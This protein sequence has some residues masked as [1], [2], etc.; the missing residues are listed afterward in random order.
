[1]RM[2]QANL[3]REERPAYLQH[4]TRD[5]L[6]WKEVVIPSPTSCPGY[7]GLQA[8]NKAEGEPRSN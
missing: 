1:M 8:S 7:A 2:S 3:N 5:T 4:V 6:K